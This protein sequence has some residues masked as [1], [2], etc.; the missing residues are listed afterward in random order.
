METT[1]K[2][3]NEIF[4]GTNGTGKTT[5][6][7]KGAIKYFEYPQ[8]ENK[9]FLIAVPDLSESKYDGIPEITVNDLGGSFG[10]GLI[11]AQYIDKGNKKAKSIYT[12]IYERYA[13]KGRKFNG[14]MINDDMGIMFGRRPVDIINMCTRKRQM[15]IDLMWNFHGLTTDCPPAFFKSV[16]GITLFKTEDNYIDTMKKIAMN[17]R[18][19][20]EESYFLVQAIT[21]GVMLDENGD[22]TDNKSEAVYNKEKKFDQYFK[23]RIS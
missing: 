19:T 16:S 4:I 6:M 5:E 14:L 13:A 21:N 15:N 12:E 1:R 8:N 2:Q 3:F 17:K 7:L 22:E 10:V 18:K 9:N 11:Q 23:L 20:F